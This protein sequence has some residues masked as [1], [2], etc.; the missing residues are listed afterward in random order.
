MSIKSKALLAALSIAA[1]M[2]SVGDEIG[3][4]MRGKLPPNGN[5]KRLH[6][7]NVK[8]KRLR[9]ITKKSKQTNRK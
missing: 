2:P 9:R 5:S 3:G 6:K 1:F 8:R 7:E 4:A